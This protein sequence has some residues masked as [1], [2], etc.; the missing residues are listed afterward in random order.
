MILSLPSEQERV[1]S[2]RAVLCGLLMAS[3]AAVAAVR[4]PDIVLNYLGS[5]KLKDVI[6]SRIGRWQFVE[7][8]GVIVPPEDQL[9]SIL[10]SDLLT[11]VYADGD[12]TIMLLI[13]Y[14]AA[15][16]GFLQVH[17]PEFCYTA[18]GFVLSDPGDHMVQLNPAKSIQ[19]QR[20][21]ATRNGSVEK[22]LYWT[23]VGDRIPTSWANQRLV[24]A[25]DNLR[26]IIP[27]AALIRVSTNAP[28]QE[29]AF[30]EM[31]LFIREMIEAVPAPLRRVLT[32]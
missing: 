27:D 5:H 21:N 9:E 1:F 13:A 25:E 23:R 19:V 20:L 3:A 7:S 2:R 15:E 30:Q 26:R 28:G 11:R 14:S 22:L 17:R 4:K 10:Y 18:A 32:A 16:T 24:I 8:S 29:E 12:K 31:D 6:P